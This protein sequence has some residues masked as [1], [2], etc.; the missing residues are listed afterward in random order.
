MQKIAAPKRRFQLDKRGQFFIRSH[1]ETLSVAAMCVSNED[2]LPVAIHA[3]HTA[4]SPTSSTELVSD[5][6]PVFHWR[7]D[8]KWS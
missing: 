4:P 8:A 2:C 7:H 5:D 6:F 3:R 1:N